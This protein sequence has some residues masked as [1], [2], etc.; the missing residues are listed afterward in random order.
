ME[1]SGAGEAATAAAVRQFLCCIEASE[2]IMDQWLR[3][4][5]RHVNS[6]LGNTAAFSTTHVSDLSFSKNKMNFRSKSAF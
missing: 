3:H 6:L 4:K 1:V 5:T 2:R